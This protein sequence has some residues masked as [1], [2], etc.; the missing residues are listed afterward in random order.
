M[1]SGLLS[2]LP[3]ACH[4]LRPAG[5]HLQSWFASPACWIL[6]C[7]PTCPLCEGARPPAA[8]VLTYVQSASSR[9]TVFAGAPHPLFSFPIQSPTP[10]PHPQTVHCLA[11]CCM[12]LSACLPAMS[13]PSASLH[14]VHSSMLLLLALD[15][16]QHYGT[17]RT[18]LSS[19]AEKQA[20]NY[21]E[22]DRKAC[23]K[24][25]TGHGPWWEL[26]QNRKRHFGQFVGASR[27]QG[28]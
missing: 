22:R 28:S 13:A 25:N 9:C 15:R 27:A 24:T 6:R 14:I 20:A 23:S 17:R 1:G 11:P 7:S 3:S 2:G 18:V 10:P 8:A 19:F 5:L 16:R 4:I 21:E 12:P 26:A